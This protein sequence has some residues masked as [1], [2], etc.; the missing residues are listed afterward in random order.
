MATVT[1]TGASSGV[2]RATARAFAARGDRV[3]LIAR[4]G[5]ALEAA[6]REVDRAGG[7]GLALTVDVADADQVERAADEIES[8]LG[9]IDVWVNNAMAAVFA[10]VRATT[11]E[12][13]RRV[14]DVTYL[15]CVHG[16]LAALRRMLARDRGVI[17]QVGSALAYRAIPLQASYC[18]AK[19]A[20]KGFTESLRTELLHDGAHVYVTMVQ[21]PALNTPQFDLVRTKLPRLPRP[22]PPVYQPEVAARAIVT[23]SERPQ[24]RERWVGIPVWKAIVGE[25]L[26]PALLD[27]YLAR[28]GYGAQ[29]RSTP[30]DERRR[31]TDYLF[32]PVP[33]DHGAHGAFDS[34][35]RTGDPQLGRSGD[36]EQQTATDPE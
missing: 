24:R 19:H 17:V 33:G 26:V 30:A 31:T 35:A 29:Q 13:F 23:A 36:R 34:E 9:P 25:R 15:G 21:L 1:I 12:E 27:R 4:S 16:T 11:A 7:R 32:E 5:D 2:G 22:V 20:I 10:P 28:T 14:T 3:A 8:A 6:R 18:A